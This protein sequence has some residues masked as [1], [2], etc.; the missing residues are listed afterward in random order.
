LS[1]AGSTRKADILPF[2]APSSSL[3][4]LLSPFQRESILWRG[5]HSISISCVRYKRAVAFVPLATD[6]L[7]ICPG[8]NHFFC[9]SPAFPY[10]FPK[11][12]TLFGF[13][14]QQSEPSTPDFD[15]PPH[16]PRVDGGRTS[17]HY[18]L[19]P[20]WVKPCGFLGFDEIA[21]WIRPDVV[22]VV[23]NPFSSHGLRPDY[24][25]LATPPS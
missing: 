17:L 10:P 19:P 14:L 13:C 2:L 9:Y 22:G 16:P 12:A 11:R 20:R 1:R 5:S 3:S 24:R 18:L 6:R 4:P 21:V 23:L 8:P 7:L 15:T 25:Q